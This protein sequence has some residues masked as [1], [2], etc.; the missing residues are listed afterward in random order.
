MRWSPSGP[1][2]GF[3]LIEV[4][5]ALLLFSVG[6]LMVMQVGAGLTTQMRYAGVRSQIAVLA[7]EKL[8]SIESE[9]FGSV[10]AGTV[11]DTIPIQ[12]WSYRRTV[13]VTSLTPV[14]ARIEI[15]LMRVDSLGPSHSVTSYTSDAW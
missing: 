13:V 15:E 1:R 2:T 10:N 5:G 8:D 3:T 6:V 11:D 7:N 9:P 4:I 14:L 12:G